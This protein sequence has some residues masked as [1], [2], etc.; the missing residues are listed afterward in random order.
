LYISFSLSL[1]LTQKILIAIHIFQKIWCSTFSFGFQNLANHDS[2]AQ[3]DAYDSKFAIE[4]DFF[5]IKVNVINKPKKDLQIF[6]NT[7]TASWGI[8]ELFIIEDASYQHK[9]ST[10]HNYTH[11]ITSRNNQLLQNLAS[12]IKYQ[13]LESEVKHH[14]QRI[15]S[16]T[17][18]LAHNSN[19]PI[20]DTG[21]KD[22]HWA[23]EL[24][25]GVDI[26]AQINRSEQEGRFCD[27]NDAEDAQEGRGPHGDIEDLFE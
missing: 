14:H 22:Q 3:Y 17:N 1:T 5:P 7:Q 12:S 23:Y 9:N 27:K 4:V 6:K 11:L 21:S 2:E 18:F 24:S 8:F 25:V 10:Y 15:N 13:I 19:K 26:I 16:A 20:K